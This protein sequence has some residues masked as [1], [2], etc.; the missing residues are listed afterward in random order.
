MAR[1]DEVSK[2]PVDRAL[3]AQTFIMAGREEERVA[4]GG[5]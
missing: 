4:T 1:I 3:T 2:A 5:S